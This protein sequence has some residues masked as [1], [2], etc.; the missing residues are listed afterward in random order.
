MIFYKAIFKI[1]LY[2]NIQIHYGKFSNINNLNFFEFIKTITSPSND[3]EKIT[4]IEGWTKKELNKILKDNFNNFEELEYDQIIA[5]TYMF[6]RGSSFV[7]L[8]QKTQDRFQKFKNKFK[9]NNLLKKF[10]FKEIMIIGSLLE[11]EGLDYNDK[12]KIYSVI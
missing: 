2:N 9:N 4:I 11:K 7:N 8:K 3:Y 6:S 5:D 10:S 1:L 12:K